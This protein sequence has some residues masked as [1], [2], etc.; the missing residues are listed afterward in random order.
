[1][2]SLEVCNLE[3]KNID[4]NSFANQFIH[5]IQILQLLTK[6]QLNQVIDLSEFLIFK[7]SYELL[8]FLVKRKKD[9]YLTNLLLVY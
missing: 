5:F 4:A 2:V 1:M 8:F 3:S 6:I 7:C 9:P